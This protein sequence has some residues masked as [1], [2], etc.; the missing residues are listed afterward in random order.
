M[1]EQ[2]DLYF[3]IINENPVEL[4][5]LSWRSSLKYGTVVLMGI[6]EGNLTTLRTHT[7]VSYSS[8]NVSEEF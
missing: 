7:N 2:R 4:R 1:G 5:L 8:K 3:Y 6:E